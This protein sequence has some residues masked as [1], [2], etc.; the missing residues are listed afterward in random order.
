VELRRRRTAARGT[1]DGE[2]GSEE[3]VCERERELGEGGRKGARPFIERG[4]EKESRPGGRTTG[5]QWRH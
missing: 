4:E 5:H 2:L 1:V 3:S